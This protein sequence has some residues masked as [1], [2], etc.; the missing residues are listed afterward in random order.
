MQAV[1]KI[2]QRLKQM[3]HE[4]CCQKRDAQNLLLLNIL[5][6]WQGAIKT[7]E[8]RSQASTEQQVN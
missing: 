1:A 2:S 5:S 6:D 8:S 7:S 3:M 4:I